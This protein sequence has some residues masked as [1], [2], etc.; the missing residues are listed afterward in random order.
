MLKWLYVHGLF[1]EHLDN[2][3][4]DQVKLFMILEIKNADSKE[5]T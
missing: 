1:G 2:L 3:Y 4:Q 5:M